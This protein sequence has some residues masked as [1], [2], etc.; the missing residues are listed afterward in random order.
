M[1]VHSDFKTLRHAYTE[2]K[3]FLEKELGTKVSCL[4]TKIDA[5]LSCAGDDNLEL[6]EKFIRKYNLDISGFDYSKHFLSEGELFGSGSAFLMLLSLPFT[7]LFWTIKTF[8]FGRVDLSKTQI[9]PD[10]E[11]QTLD[12]TFGDLLTWYLTGKYSLREEI[13][14]KLK[15][16]L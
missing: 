8:T 5:D 13:R 4:K 10:R 6:L 7:F 12:M 3:A 15:N 14:F 16:T 9:L 11:R 2:V 1:I